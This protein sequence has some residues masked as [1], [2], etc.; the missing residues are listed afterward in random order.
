[1]LEF[2]AIFSA[3]SFSIPYC[4]HNT[5][6]PI[7]TAS[8]AMPGASF[9]GRNISTISIFSGIF[10]KLPITVSPFIISPSAKGL[11]GIT[12]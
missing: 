10:S 3:S 2:S 6:L 12:F 8:F 9:E 7:L 5:L 4:N 11:T 1:M